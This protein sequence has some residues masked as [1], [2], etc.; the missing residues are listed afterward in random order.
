[1]EGGVCGLTEVLLV[2]RHFLEEPEKTM[3]ELPGRDWNRA[4]PEHRS[5][6][7]PIPVE[8]GKR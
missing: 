4:L 1:M 8:R 2:F 6:V 7:L 3:E 5:G